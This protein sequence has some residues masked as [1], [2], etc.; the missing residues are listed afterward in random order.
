LPCELDIYALYE[1]VF[2]DMRGDP[3]RASTRLAQRRSVLDAVAGDLQALQR[4][5]GPNERNKLD[6]H[7]TAVRDFEQRLSS[8]VSA[9]APACS[10]PQPSLLGVPTSGQGNEDNAPVLLRLFMEFIAVTVACNM[11]G[12]LSFQFG[13]GGDHFHYGWL[14]IPGMPEDAHDLV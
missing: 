13:R 8:P 12:V 3:S 1:K 5:L 7:L 11:V 2:G 6:I 4:R 14:N 9:R 10:A